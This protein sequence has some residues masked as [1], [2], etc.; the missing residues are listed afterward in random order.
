MGK[1]VW[2][3]VMVGETE[4]CYMGWKYSK[5][6][7]LLYWSSSVM[8][9]F[10]SRTGGNVWPGPSPK[11]V[12]VSVCDWV[13]ELLDFQ[14]V[15]LQVWKLGVRFMCDKLPTCG[16]MGATPPFPPPTS[17]PLF[18]FFLLSVGGKHISPTA[19]MDLREC[20]YWNIQKVQTFPFR[21]LLRTS[22]VVH[23]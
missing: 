8:S 2:T 10:F 11:C 16:L 12:W 22:F 7:R 6:A 21:F 18:F 3:R 1:G 5:Y 15:E 17:F 20:K 19:W 14:H 13:S 23:P 9:S 4:K